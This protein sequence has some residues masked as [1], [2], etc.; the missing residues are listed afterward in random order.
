[1]SFIPDYIV[2]RGDS[3]K[4]AYLAAKEFDS[5]WIE[6]SPDY[7]PTLL[8]TKRYHILTTEIFSSKE[9]AL[10]WLEIFLNSDYQSNFKFR[11]NTAGAL[12]L[13][14]SNYLFFPLK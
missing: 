12:I 8:N 9:T 4:K 6:A 2:S 7:N 14:N 13:E 1:M 11:K 3:G 5:Y 10:A